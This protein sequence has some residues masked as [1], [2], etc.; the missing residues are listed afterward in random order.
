MPIFCTHNQKEFEHWVKA[1]K[2]N[3]INFYKV[4]LKEFNLMKVYEYCME[5]GGN[6]ID[7]DSFE[8]VNV[9]KT[10]DINGFLYNIADVLFIYDCRALRV[11]EGC[12]HRA[13][14]KDISPIV[15]YISFHYWIKIINSLLK[16][17][18]EVMNNEEL[19]QKI[20]T[21]VFTHSSVILIVICLG[22]MIHT[23]THLLVDC[24]VVK[25]SPVKRVSMDD[26]KK[27]LVKINEIFDKVYSTLFGEKKENINLLIA[28]DEEYPPIDLDVRKDIIYRYFVE[29]MK[30]FWGYIYD[31]SAPTE[32]E[33]LKHIL[34]ILENI[35]SLSY[36]ITYE[37][38]KSL[39]P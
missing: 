3:L 10:T 12:L 24:Y 11:Y 26:L 4:L 8:P 37:T 39:Q 30:E 27:L 18:K 25:T 15:L 1:T 17:Y 33:E 28:N 31:D 6:E 38:H 13:K 19:K 36:K 22:K 5:I 34:E 21:R 9:M 14:F 2:E 20:N 35:C 29:C 16:E 32:N 23:I 7:K